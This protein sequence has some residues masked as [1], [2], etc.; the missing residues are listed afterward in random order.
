MIWGEQ[1]CDIDLKPDPGFFELAEF[2][3]H[4]Q[5]FTEM[6]LRALLARGGFGDARRFKR[7]AV[8]VF[9]ELTLEVYK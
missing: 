3:K 9:Y 1:G 7:H 5:G 2:D 8:E 6:T 4:C